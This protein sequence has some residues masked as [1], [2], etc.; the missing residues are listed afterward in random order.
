MDRGD[1]KSVVT[2]WEMFRDI[3]KECTNDECSVSRVGGHRSLKR[4]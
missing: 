2:E 1:G 3:V 4:M